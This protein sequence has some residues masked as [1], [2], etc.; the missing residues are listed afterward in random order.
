AVVTAI[1][2]AG[3]LATLHRRAASLGSERTALIAR[4]PLPVGRAITAADVETVRRYASQL[5]DSTIASIDDLRGRVV[6]VPVVAGAY[7]S[8]DNLAPRDR[9]GLDGV[10]PPGMRAVRV[11]VEVAPPLEPGVAVDVLSTFDP[12][13]VTDE[14]PTITVAAG[15]LVLAVDESPDVRAG[16]GVT[17]LVDAID[18]RRLAFATATGV[19][20]VAIVPPEEASFPLPDD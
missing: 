5:P 1:V 13:V 18:A 9:T 2:V 15:V 12:A 4:H 19:V 17:L 20:T 14:E 8:D 11:V 3:D 6:R 7:L 16:T 10:V